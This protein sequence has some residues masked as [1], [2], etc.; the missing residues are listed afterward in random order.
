[1]GR[2]MNRLTIRRIACA[3]LAATLSLAAPPRATAQE[4]PPRVVPEEVRVEHFEV[5][6]ARV[7]DALR[8]LAETTGMSV[9]ATAKAAEKTV[10]LRVEGALAREVLA[11]LA[12]VAG[13]AVRR[14]P[15]SRVHLVMTTDEY[16]DDLVVGRRERTRVFTLLHPNA[17]AVATAIRDLFGPRVILT[18]GVDEDQDGFSDGATSRSRRTTRSFQDEL[19][20][21]GDSRQLD[22]ARGGGSSATTRRD[23]LRQQPLTAG[24][25]QA[26][27]RARAAGESGLEAEVQKIE[28]TDRAIYV[29]SN[30]RN[31]LVLVR[32]SDEEAMSDIERLVVEMDRPTPQVLLEVKILEAL[33][34][35]GFR[36]VV[37][38]DVA[39]GHRE[40]GPPSSAPRN[41]LLPGAAEGRGSVG[42]IGNFPLEGGTLVY[43]FMNDHLRARLQILQEER[44]VRLLGTPML[45]CANDQ[46]ARLFV[47]EERPLV[48]NFTLQTNVSQGVVTDRVVP[49]VEL[50]DVGTT[51]RIIP[52]INADRTVTLTIL[53]DSSS[54]NTGAARIPVPQSGG[55]VT[56]VAVDTVTT[57]TVE[58]VIVGK[59]R[60]MLAVGGLF[61]EEDTKSTEKVPV[62]GDVPLLGLLFRR[63]VELKERRELV[64]LVTPHVLSTP[65]E[66]EDRSQERLRDLSREPS[67]PPAADEKR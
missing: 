40:F 9:G 41:P 49:T 14:D 60:K 55:G 19:R 42:G 7:D 59:D 11:N 56:E 38:V 67:W 46:E 30:R 13:V 50:Q 29:T 44:R 20:L 54:T 52:R 48:R 57:T 58:A 27:E 21:D 47:G 31:N 12:R 51:L 28:A 63:D 53:Q 43:Q 25:A 32:T 16:R 4:A 26:L 34:A 33:V 65:A 36:S 18:E 23:A 3:I 8:L 10:S 1:M 35:D 64:L 37:D 5:R 2:P 62:L 61:R 17:V 6:G 45:L 24:Q 22:E 39:T 15:D 66:G